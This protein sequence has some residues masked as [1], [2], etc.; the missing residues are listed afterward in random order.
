MRILKF[1]IALFLIHF[2]FPLTNNEIHALTDM[3][4]QWGNKLNW[5]LPI[6]NNACNWS[7][8]TCNI[9]TNNVIRMY[10]K[11]KKLFVSKYF[12]KTITKRSI[13]RHT[14]KFN[15]K[16]DCIKLFVYFIM[17]LLNI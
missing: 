7:G 11:F 9:T 3:Y 2:V 4:K 1:I 17:L 16:Y 13:N 12:L 8:I 10:V 5:K 15:C 6:F 14:S